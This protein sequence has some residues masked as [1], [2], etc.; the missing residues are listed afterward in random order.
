MSAPSMIERS[1]IIFSASL[2]KS[3]GVMQFTV[4]V[5]KV[6][7]SLIIANRDSI[8]GDIWP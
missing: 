8:S 1:R 7:Q 5:R 6:V 3:F 4:P 2:K